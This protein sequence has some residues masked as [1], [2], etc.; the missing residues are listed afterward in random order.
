MC[1]CGWRRFCLQ[2]PGPQVSWQNPTPSPYTYQTTRA[3][4]KLIIQCVSSQ[5]VVETSQG[6][7]TEQN[8]EA[9]TK[10]RNI[11]QHKDG[12]TLRPT[13]VSTLPPTV[14]RNHTVATC[15]GPVPW[16]RLM[17]SQINRHP[18]LGKSKTH[19]F[20]GEQTLLQLPG[21]PETNIMQT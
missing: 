4:V 18:T 12:V 2:F 10:A 1:G 16:E 21:F 15:V 5:K 8:L 3:C 13:P 14:W 6:P 17:W 19:P 9:E 20:C 11:K 7:Q